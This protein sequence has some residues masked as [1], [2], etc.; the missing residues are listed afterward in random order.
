MQLTKT[1]VNDISYSAMSSSYK[2]IRFAQ[3]QKL[4]NQTMLHGACVRN[5]KDICFYESK[6]ILGCSM[7]RETY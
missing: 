2:S 4:A 6:K 3:L 5:G 7:K 1:V